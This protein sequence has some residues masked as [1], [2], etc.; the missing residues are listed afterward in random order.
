MYVS[1]ILWRRTQSMKSDSLYRC[2]MYVRIP[3]RMLA[4]TIG[5]PKAWKGA[6]MNSRTICNLK[7]AVCWVIETTND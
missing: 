6:S 1:E 7:S 3:W 4:G 5:D 2:I